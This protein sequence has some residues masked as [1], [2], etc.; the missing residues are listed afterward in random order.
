MNET[1]PAIRAS[2]TAV[3][4]LGP[5]RHPS[6][7]PLSR[8][9]GD[10]I[11][12]FVPDEARVRYDIDLKT[13]APDEPDV[14]F[15]KAGP[16]AKLYFEPGGC[17]AA[18][19]TCGGLCPGLNNVI[20]SL[21]RQLS[22]YGVPRVL[23]V[24]Y[25]YQG[26]S[27]RD[28]DAPIELSP[29]FVDN[30]HQAGGTVLGASRG[31]QPTEVMLD[32]LRA[33]GVNLVFPIGGDGTQ[34]GARELAQAAR[35][36]GYD[37]AVVGVPK[38]IDND[39][40]FIDRSFGF[41]TA[42]AAAQRVLACAHNEARGAPDG[43]GLVK[44][45]GREAG[46]IAAAAAV[47]NQEVNFVLIPEIPFRLTGPGSLCELLAARMARKHHAVIV[48]AEGA[49]QH[50]LPGDHGRDASGNRRHGDIGLFLSQALTTHFRDLGRPVNLKYI[51]PSYIIRSI[52]ANA[53]DSLLCDMLAR[54]AVHA[55]L[56]GKTEMLVGTWKS[57]FIH[58]PIG[59]AVR[60]KKR[61]D[62]EGDLWMSVYEATN[63]PLRMTP[64]D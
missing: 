3:A 4:T 60:Q 37:L 17:T 56:A 32:T 64:P 45:M 42:I 12:N 14:F 33:W 10:G 58:L 6:P 2:E 63:Q 55:A 51:D 47:A 26:L 46:F 44:L 24:R 53:D 48:V 35:A 20:R 52:P 61:V 25:G 29:E 43:I 16:R 23:G 57:E 21:Y 22:N 36:A 27:G 49:G 9:H 54:D 18:I 40:A 39:L 62:P 11:G 34:R 5:R 15:E 41:N 28:C 59:L 19:L 31:H 1:R 7:L 8:T 13:G 38:T 50:L 30:I